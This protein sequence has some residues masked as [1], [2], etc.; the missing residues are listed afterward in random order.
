[1][2]KGLQDTAAPTRAVSQAQVNGLVS[3]VLPQGCWRDDDYLWLTDRS[4]RLVE[5]TDGYLEILPMP[6][7]GHQ[8][9]LAF[10]FMAFRQ[11]LAPAG[12]E[13]LF[14]PLRLRIREGKFREPDLLAVRDAHDPRSGNRF[15]TGA[16][17]VVEVVSPD[18]EERDLIDKRSDYAEAAIPEYWIVDPRT[19]TISVLKLDADGYV[20]HGAHGRGDRATSS[21]LAG[22]SIDVAQVFDAAGE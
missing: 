2:G 5:F 7:R 18:G 19:E 15:W 22:F 8:R 13:A 21:T 12:G 6:S 14:A 9:V 4:P 17:V 3:E 16:D 20:E 10:L 11:F 1:M